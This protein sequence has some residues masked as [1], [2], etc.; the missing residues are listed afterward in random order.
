MIKLI[1]GITLVIY[2]TVYTVESLEGHFDNVYGSEDSCIKFDTK[3]RLITIVCKSA[4]L[5]DIEKQVDNSSILK[6]ES[7]DSISNQLRPITSVQGNRIWILNAGIIVGKNAS[8]VI[9]STD[10]A[11]LKIVPVPTVQLS[12]ESKMTEEQEQNNPIVLQ[13]NS[14]TASSKINDKENEVNVNNKNRNRS[15][16]NI[17]QN[18]VIVS[19]N[20]DNNPNGIHVYGSLKIDSVKITSWD[21]KKYDV[22]KF[23]LGKRPGE[24][25]TKSEYDTV[26]PRPFIRVS[27]QA[28]GTTNITNSELAYLGYSCSK[29][30]GLS[31]YGGIGS[32]VRGND[33]H[34][35]LKGFYSNKMGYMI[36]ENNNFHD[37]YLYGS[38]PHTGTH[39]MIIR[40]N[41]VHHNNATAVVCAKDCYNILIEGN[42]VYNNMDT[43]RGI[44]FS[45]NSDHS[46]AQN[47]YVHDQ[48]I[49]IGINRFSDFNEIFNNTLSNCNTAIDLTDTSNNI[50]HDNK[51]VGA[52]YGVVL[53]NVTNKIFDN[54]IY[55]STNGIV[56]IHTS[57]NT[58]KDNVHST[59]NDTAHTPFLDEINTN[60]EVKGTKNPIT[61]ISN[62]FT[63]ES[64]LGQRDIENKTKLTE[65]EDKE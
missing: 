4:R 46:I 32:V 21:P 11:W 55:N 43:H 38:D 44:A 35:L 40:N 41:K 61:V 12:S 24:E 59:N 3:T 47:N 53:Q 45:I 14:T 54:K 9:D 30:S 2:L 28:S 63:S 22:V 52:K 19:K 49:C 37:N 26:E 23:K 25:D 50:V 34:H 48:D 64:E 7:L 65:D 33:I 8:L 36:I 51:I 58:E 39:D 16:Y 18:A 29:C 1:F 13:N 17:I 27:S 42:E 60:N 5:S 56:L 15:S 10:T 57:N 62:P 31:Y 20:N 6:R